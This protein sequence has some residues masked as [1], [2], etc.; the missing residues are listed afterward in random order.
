MKELGGT[1]GFGVL[2]K[3]KTFCGCIV[4]VWVYMPIIRLMI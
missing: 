3:K 2:F 1:G 4:R